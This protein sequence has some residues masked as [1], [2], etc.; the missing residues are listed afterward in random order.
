ML[1]LEQ[2]SPIKMIPADLGSENVEI[3]VADLKGERAGKTL[4]VTAGMDG[5]EY[6]G[7]GAAYELIRRYNGQNFAG[8][9]IIV[10]IVNRLGFKEECSRNPLDGKYPKAIVRGQV[11]GSASE[12]LIYW[13]DS[14]YVRNADFWCDLH[15]GSLTERLYPFIWLYRSGVFSL[16][17]QALKL[18]YQFPA[19][20]IVFQSVSSESRAGYWARHNCFSALFESG[21]RGEVR[22]EDIERQI[23]WLECVMKE[24]GMIEETASLA[25]KVQAMIY[26]K[27]EYLGAPFDGLWRPKIRSDRRVASAEILGECFHFDGT[28]GRNILTAQAGRILWQKET[29]SMRRGDILAAVAY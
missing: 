22:T 17:A 1:S 7:I 28:S 29:L 3:P 15:G 18:A 26:N 25:V 9:L 8:R 13:L 12:R 27:I 10:P 16:D 11:K 24:M 5:D 4:L 6:A 14:N 23:L 19:D 21:G 2:S 20:T